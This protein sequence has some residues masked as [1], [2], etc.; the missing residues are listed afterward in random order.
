MAD[1]SRTVPD[2]AVMGHLLATFAALS[3]QE[4]IPA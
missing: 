2:S 4:R 3:E 1:D